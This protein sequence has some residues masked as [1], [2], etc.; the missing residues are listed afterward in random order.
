MSLRHLRAAGSSLVLDAR[1]P[2]APTVLHWG[3]DLGDLS[4]QDLGTLAH[5][6]VPAVPP[7]S[8]DVPLRFSL[9]P[10]ARDGWTGRPGLSGAWADG[11]P[12]PTDLTLVAA[13]APGTRAGALLTDAAGDGEQ[14]EYLLRD[15]AGTVEVR[16]VVVMSPEGVVV[17]RHDVRNL[18]DVPLHLASLDAV[19]PVPA[20]AEE[21]LDFTGLWASERRPQRARPGQGVWSRE[22]RHGRPGHDDPFLMVLG[23]PDF[24]FRRGEVWSAHLAWSG[25]KRLWTE[26][27]ALGVRSLGA[28]E[29]LAPGE[30]VLAPGDSYAAPEL[31]LAWSGEGLDG[32][33]ARFHPWQRRVA[34]VPRPR[35][36]VLNVWEAVYFDHDA[37]RLDRLA[38]VAAEVG[39][40][41]FVLDDGWFLGRR[42]DTAGLGDW[43]V[44][45][46]VW[47]S[48]LHPLV[49]S[50]VGR[51][52][53]LGL[54]V[55]PE[56]VNPDS[57]LARAHPDWL[58][59][60][61]GTPTWRNQRVLDLANADAYAHVRDQLVAVL[62]EY[63]VRYLKWDQNADL[64]AHGAHAQTL[65]TYRLMDE[66]RAFRPGLE[67]ESCSS[68]GGR[69][70]LGV[71]RRA[72]RVWVS[73]TND[74][75]DRQ[76]IQRW[77]GVLVPPEHLGGH[78]G[79]RRAHITGRAA[80]LGFRL[81]TAFFGSAG[82][83]RDLTRSDAAE[84]AVVAAWIAEHK[85]RRD[86]LHSGV[87]V[88]GD[89]PDGEPQVHGVVAPDGGAGV[90][91][92]VRLGDSA[93]ALP[94]PVRLVGLDPGRR[95]RVR[96][97]PLGVVDGIDDVTLRDVLPGAVAD[98]PPPWL[99]AAALPEGADLPGRVL[100]EV[101]LA[102][103][104]LQPEQALVLTADA[105]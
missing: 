18:R 76:R 52:M 44:D 40:E 49:R 84:R 90:F 87:V 105:V 39:V 30:V 53:E 77:T 65:A 70:D 26:S 56:M 62:D 81:A 104:L 86:L 75:L 34:P 66:L 8:L 20:R 4:P 46:D 71:L 13:P 59:G 94:A 14:L 97:L 82:I 28:G 98:A 15:G 55:E 61:P 93:S 95:Y 51:G 54:W 22:T 79:D 32:L 83:E 2:G 72:G 43:V 6:L 36:V 80:S 21:V 17:V 103:L 3:A 60:G 64:L 31:L 89:T 33:S 1:G 48:G 57:D 91:A 100:A 10:S 102:N 42:D 50:V 7:S 5:V 16:G 68:G 92:V 73:D 74:P 88:R 38:Q 69:V 99:A 41:R 27:S 67:I 85:A 47:P 58:L 78:V 11:R 23:T 37:D 35:P 12:L 25:D 63:P 24:G 45:P 96:V 19:V 101:G 9:L 29:L